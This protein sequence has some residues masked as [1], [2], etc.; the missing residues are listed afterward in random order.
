MFAIC[1]LLKM[2]CCPKSG[3]LVL[4]SPKGCPNLRSH[5]FGRDA[6]CQWK[7][8]KMLV[9]AIVSAVVSIPIT[10]GYE[11]YMSNRTPSPYQTVVY[12]TYNP[13]WVWLD[14]QGRVIAEVGPH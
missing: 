7:W 4:I 1:S 13:G 6:M 11:N 9:G 8:K 3:G 14:N 5:I 12:E 2:G 10:R